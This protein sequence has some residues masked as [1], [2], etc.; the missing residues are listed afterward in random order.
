MLFNLSKKCDWKKDI[1]PIYI[2]EILMYLK[3]FVIYLHLVKCHNFFKHLA[4][5]FTKVF[6]DKS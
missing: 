5:F 6:L 3:N 2:L 1:Y 4:K